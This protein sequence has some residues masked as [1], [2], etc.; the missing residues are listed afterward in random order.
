MAWRRTA[1]R[2]GSATEAGRWSVVVGHRPFAPCSASCSLQLDDERGARAKAGAKPCVGGL[3]RAAHHVH[4]AAVVVY[5]E[6]QPEA[7][8]PGSR[9]LQAQVLGRRHAKPAAAQLP[10]Q[11]GVG[12]QRPAAWRGKQGPGRVRSWQVIG[13]A[14]G[15]Q[16][17]LGETTAPGEAGKPGRRRARVAAAPGV[18]ADR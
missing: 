3:L 9:V 11:R 13:A 16:R 15:C 17:T 6:V 12:R 8:L 18:S 14:I 5:E 2:C 10:P 7:R 1:E 4:E